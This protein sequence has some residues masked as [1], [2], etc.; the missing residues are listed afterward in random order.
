MLK[1]RFAN[2]GERGSE[3]PPSDDPAVHTWRNLRGGV[4]AR[5]FARDGYRWMFWPY[6]ANFR[7][8]L[9]DGFITAFPEPGAPVDVIW[10]TYRRSVL[11]M[12]LQVGGF[13]ALHASA[14]LS[15]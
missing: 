7:F 2:P 13:E 1:L 3:P 9:Q 4:V 12:A 10:D 5:G 15:Q 14:I 11:P 6:L 8:D